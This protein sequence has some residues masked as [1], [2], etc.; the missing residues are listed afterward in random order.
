MI[1]GGQ[2]EL[3]EVVVTAPDPEWLYEFARSLVADRL[4][5]NAHNFEPVRSAYRWDGELRERTEGRVALHTRRS[6]VARI[7]ERAEK[8]HPYMV[9]SVSARPIYD[10]NPRY[11]E[12]IAAET[13][14]G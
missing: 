11:L 10:G 6:L 1:T 7:V 4:A 3:C 12:W 13:R 2:I 9:P 8:D 5:S 14:Q